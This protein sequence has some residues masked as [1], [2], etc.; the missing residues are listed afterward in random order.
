MDELSNA[1]ERLSVEDLL[2]ALKDAQLKVQVQQEEIHR[3]VTTPSIP[4]STRSPVLSPDTVF[5]V[6]AGSSAADSA[7]NTMAPSLFDSKDSQKK[8]GYPAMKMVIFAHVWFERKNL[9]GIRLEAAHHE[10][11]AATLTTS[12]D[13]GMVRPSPERIFELRLVLKL[14]EY[15]PPETLAS[16]IFEGI[17]PA[18]HFKQGLDHHEDPICQHLLGFKSMGV[19]DRHPP[20][21]FA[22]NFITGATVFRTLPGVKILT[23]LLWG[24]T[25]LDDQHTVTKNTN[26]DL[27]QITKVNPVAIAFAAIVTRYLLTGDPDFTLVGQKSNIK[28]MADFEYYV[29]RIEDQLK[30]GT[31]LMQDTIRFYNDH[32]FPTTRDH[33]STIPTT[34]P[35]SLNEE[36]EN[37]WLELEALNKQPD[38]YSEGVGPSLLTPA[39]LV[40]MP[41]AVPSQIEPPMISAPVMNEVHSESHVVDGNDKDSAEAAAEAP[42]P[43]VARER[44]GQNGQQEPSDGHSL[45][46][47]HM[48]TAAMVAVSTAPL[49]PAFQVTSDQG[50]SNVI[51]EEGE[52]DEDDE[53]D[54][55]DEDKDE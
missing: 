4:R 24:S 37:F 9:F 53:E 19:Y 42:I 39:V 52:D 10:L 32:V 33:H 8:L 3:L 16:G 14:Y 55:E 20:C 51:D 15:L 11:N 23:C 26:A 54:E 17:V 29:E 38:L 41:L 18:G 30:K 35:M 34:V 13:T 5:A 7:S 12:L 21:L 22:D 6:E 45:A 48:S 50:T 47:S 43:K 44:K 49:A 40:G 1:L 31:N 46:N 36:E 27:W 28:Y 25:A 2:V